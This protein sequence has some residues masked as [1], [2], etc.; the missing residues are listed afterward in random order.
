VAGVLLLQN[1]RD[2]YP[3]DHP[4]QYS[5]LGLSLWLAWSLLLLFSSGSEGPVPPADWAGQSQP[6]SP[7]RI[8]EPARHD[9][10]VTALAPG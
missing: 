9:E 3:S 8:S 1:P 10:P 7:S 4:D 2:D 5:K 6:R